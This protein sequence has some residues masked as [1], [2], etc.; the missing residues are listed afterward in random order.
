MSVK[1]KFWSFLEV[2]AKHRSFGYFFEVLPLSG[3]RR[4]EALELGPSPGA[5][6]PYARA[7]LNC[8]GSAR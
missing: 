6:A 2:I 1:S 7:K 5:V 8:F 4:F 3:L